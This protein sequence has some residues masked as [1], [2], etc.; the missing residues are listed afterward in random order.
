MNTPFPPP[1]AARRPRALWPWLLGCFTLLLLAGVL[2]VAAIW[3]GIRALGQMG[4]QMVAAIPGVQAQFG[5]ISDVGIDWAGIRAAAVAGRQAIVLDLS[6]AT[7]TGQL[8]LEI[9]PASGAF[10]GAILTLPS[11][12]VREFDAAMLAQLQALQEG[13]MLPLLPLLLPAP[14]AAPAPSPPTPAEPEPEPVPEAAP[15]AN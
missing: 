9:D 7:G 10:R 5:E 15:P 3:F 8:E 11:G 1:P 14:E 12:E 4:N 2:L 6:G 13:Q